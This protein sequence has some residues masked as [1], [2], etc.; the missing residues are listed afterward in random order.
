MNPYET[1]THLSQ[2][3][4]FHYGS[5]EETLGDMPGPRAGLNFPRR[6][7]SELIG[8]MGRDSSAL[9]VGCAVGR[10]TF[11]LAR[12]ASSVVGID[13]SQSFISAAQNL[14]KAGQCKGTTVVEGSLLATF[15]AKVPVGIECQRVSFEVGDATDLRKDLA[16]FDAVLAANLICRLSDPASFLSRVPKL[17]KPGGQFLLS[18]PFSWLEEFTPR[19]NWLG[20][21]G[22]RSFDVIKEILTPDFE[23]QTT[24][25]M[26]FLIREHE[27]KFQY[28]ISLG[29]RWVR[30]RV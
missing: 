9:D 20:G 13:S 29:S 11:E 2:Y 14:Q 16:G 23:L 12:Y 5:E 1:D 15:E 21:G 3:L 27:R 18:T 26:P 24:K 6:C 4:L 7:V 8:P 30:R 19:E 17:V 28:G 10:S 22:Q 25:E